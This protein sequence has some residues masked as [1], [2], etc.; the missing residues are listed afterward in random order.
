MSGNLENWLLCKLGQKQEYVILHGR[1]L[2]PRLPEGFED[3]SHKSGMN[4]RW[5]V[6]CTGDTGVT[7]YV[8]TDADGSLTA[9]L[10]QLR[11]RRFHHHRRD[12]ERKK[13]EAF[14]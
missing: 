3:L 12:M 6:S 11:E 8:E 13:I 9:Y 4:V 14:H 2:Y 1:V 7:L 10:R 5:C